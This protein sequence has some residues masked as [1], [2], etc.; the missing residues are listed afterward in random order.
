MPS[1]FTPNNV[2]G[3]TPA[4]GSEEEL[5][6]P[7]GQT[8]RAKRVTIEDMMTTG[9][10]SQVDSLTA[11]VSQ[12]VRGV[13]GGKGVADGAPVVDSS[14]LGDSAAMQAMIMMADRCIPQ[15]VVSP[16]VMLHFEE[17]TVGK[18]KVTKKLTEEQREEIRAE[19]PGVI[20]TDQIDLTDKMHLFEW[21]VGGLKSFMSFREGASLDVGSLG[22]KPVGKKSA[23]RGPRS[24]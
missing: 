3:S 13:K 21:G 6:L 5:T 10:L 7:S 4:E 24:K 12:Y 19:R 18:T 11:Q 9:V 20:F 16:V 23:K 2:W 15:I 14:L 22:T 8:C 1:D 17:R